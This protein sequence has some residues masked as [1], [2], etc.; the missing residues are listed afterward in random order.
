MLLHKKYKTSTVI[1]GLEV[2]VVKRQ[3]EVFLLRKRVKDSSTPHYVDALPF[4]LFGWK[5][6]YDPAKEYMYWDADAYNLGV[7]EK[8]LKDL[9][10][11]IKVLESF[12]EGEV[13]LATGEL[14]RLLSTGV[15]REDND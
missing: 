15:L 14:D 9:K 8:E 10:S 7:V 3:K 4:G 2:L 6:L 1:K 13:I 5:T 11:E 12:G